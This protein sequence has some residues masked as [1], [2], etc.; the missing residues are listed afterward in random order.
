MTDIQNKIVEELKEQDKILKEIFRRRK[1][2]AGISKDR[3]DYE[4]IWEALMT[5]GENHWDF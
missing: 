3:G 1:Q 5:D 2:L 4:K